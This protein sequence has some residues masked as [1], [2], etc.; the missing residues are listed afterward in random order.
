LTTTFCLFCRTSV[1]T[2]FACVEGK[3]LP[4]QQLVLLGDLQRLPHEESDGP[5]EV[6]AV[7]DSVEEGGYHVEQLGHQQAL[8]AISS[9]TVCIVANEF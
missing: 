4:G 5:K 2:F 7:D 8:V 3:D 1:L 6:P 9:C